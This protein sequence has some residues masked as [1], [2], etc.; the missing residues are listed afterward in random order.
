MAA[1]AGIQ[2][3]LFV[4]VLLALAWPLGTYM[5]KVADGD[6]P[7]LGCVGRPIER[8]I[9]RAAGVDPSVEMDW[10]R[11]AIA[12]IAFSGVGVLFLYVLQRIQFWLPLN[13][14]ILP[15][16]SPDS[17]FNTAVSFVTNTSWQGY[18]GESTLS[19]VSQMLGITAQSFLSAATGMAVL[20]ALARA[21]ARREAKTIG[22]FWVDLT[23][24]TLYILL[25][26][27]ILFALAFIWQGALQNFKQ[28]ETVKT[29]QTTSF[30]GA[31]TDASGAPGNAPTQ[32]VVVSSQVLPMGPV[33]SQESIKLLGGDGGGFFNANSAHPY[34]NPTPLSNFLQM[35]AILLIPAGLCH[36]FGAMVGDRRQGM[37]LLAAMTIL[38]VSMAAITIHAE[39]TGVRHVSTTLTE[40]G[41]AAAER[42]SPGLA[43]WEGKEERFGVVSSALYAAVTTSGGDGAVNAMHDSF[44]PIGGMMPLALMQTSEVVFGG[45]G[46]GL[47]SMIV[48]ALLAVFIAGLMIGRAPEYLGKKVDVF[49][50]KMVAV[51]VL[52]TPILVLSGT[53]LSLLL[54]EG[55]AGIGNPGAHGFSEV[56]YAF[57]SAANNNGSSFA[58]LSVN[59]PFYNVM[60]AIAMWLG[61]FAVVIPVLAIAGSLASK[62]RRAAGAGTLTTYQPL[63]I[64]VLIGTIL[65]VASLTFMPAMALGP[66]AEQLAAAS[67]R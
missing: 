40:P 18:A 5:A 62:R 23:R 45:P 12:L 47:F 64:A 17:A 24:C 14:Q 2:I 25:P 22:N 37:A 43:N 57:T 35:I 38:F 66:L 67:V 19:Y 27:S 1:H 63:F 30:R 54:P 36:T 60:L 39:Q 8:L 15:G 55:L 29:V 16:V 44:T 31:P 59:T 42:A 58:G 11:Y 34:E 26:L 50:M 13:P 3:G 28:Y 65:L 10:M 33:A 46:S 61:R 20:F 4:F 51:A 32:D 49:E 48:D 52:A 6:V 7:L 41:R 56:L 9:Y 21:F 53:A